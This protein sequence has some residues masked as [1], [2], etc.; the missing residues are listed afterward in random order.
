MTA[1]NTNAHRLS[2]E[3]SRIEPEEGGFD[4][5]AISRYREMLLSLRRRGIEP[6]VTLHHF[7]TPLWAAH[8]GGWTNPAIVQRFRHFV[9][10]IV[11]ALRDLVQFWC[12][13]DPGFRQAL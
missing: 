5:A 11:A 7:T 8:Q 9:E 6:M 2:I 10:Y 3:W 4:Q 1:L 12:T 13:I